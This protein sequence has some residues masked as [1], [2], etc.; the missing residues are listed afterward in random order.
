MAALLELGVGFD[1]EFTGRRNLY[2]GGAL[3]GF[4][5]EEIARRESGI[6]EFSGLGGEIDRPVKTYSAG[7]MLRLAF[8]LATSFEPEVLIVD[9]V[10]AVGDGEFQSRCLD[11]I[12]GL[13]D[14]GCT[15][16]LCS[17]ALHQIEAFCSRALWL[18]RG[19]VQALGP[20]R[21]VVGRYRDFC[22]TGSREWDPAQA[23]EA[24]SR[25]IC[26]IE[27]VKLERPRNGSFRTG[28][29]LELDVSARFLTEFR[30][31]PGLG[32]AVVRDDGVVVY[33]TS[34][35]FDGVPLEETGPGEYRA[36]L[37]LPR[38]ALL[39]G[40]YYF[41]VVAT[42]TAGLQSYDLAEKKE[43]FSVTHS[44][45]D[46]GLLRLQT[47]WGQEEKREKGKSGRREEGEQG[48]TRSA[49]ERIRTGDLVALGLDPRQ[50][51]RL[52]ADVNRLLGTCSSAECWRR[53]SRGLLSPAHPFPVHKLLHRTVFDN[54]RDAGPAP[55][56][57]PAPESV[58]DTNLA[59]LQERLGL[60]SY[61]ELHSWTVE[62][63]SGYWE[64]MIRHLGIRFRTPPLK[65]LES[66]PD[67]ENAAW[68]PGARLNIAE[69]CFGRGSDTAVVYQREGRPLSSLTRMGLDS[70]RTASPTHC[71][72]W[73]W[74]GAIRSPSTCP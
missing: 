40:R 14:R 18:H 4:S 34:T 73:G 13:R 5:R 57:V 16:V 22:Q 64:S 38:L 20:S 62:N 71:P 2:F 37:V 3:A 17:H 25:K 45:S 35:I 28:D 69:S 10:L 1:P 21:E 74:I 29:S 7:M 36:R 12:Q 50:A 43:P 49:A 55:I 24:G 6:I 52:S 8:S 58:R 61:A 44:G 30:G 46:S 51:R 15:A 39:E 27:E 32:V 60:G 67:A 47:E 63:R 72:A 11:R 41:N 59:R 42:D 68:L 31:T 65:I 19:R 56:F 70:S 66:T 53:I 48:V 9:E 33:V 54:E 26:W 23:R